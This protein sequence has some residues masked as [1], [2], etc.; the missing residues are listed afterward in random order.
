[1]RRVAD[2]TQEVFP[3]ESRVAIT[4]SGES[5]LLTSRAAT[6]LAVITNELITNALKHGRPASDG[7]RRIEVRV[8]REASRLLLEVWNSGNPVP[9]GFTPP[10]GQSGMGLP[11]V[12][13]LIV[14]QYGGHFSLGPA[15]EGTAARVEVEISRCLPKAA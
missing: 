13:G 5:L 10:A 12:Q 4:A 14:D 1:M 11:L 2:L 6:T 15:R 3:R 7:I 8:W 9:E